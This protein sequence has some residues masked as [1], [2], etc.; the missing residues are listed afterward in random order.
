M[1][2]VMK[3]VSK[4]YV[5]NAK[6]AKKIWPGAVVFDVT[7]GGA[8]EKMDP[9]FPIE[10]VLIPGIKRKKSLSIFGMWE[11]LKIFEKKREIDESYFISEKKLGK[12]RKCKSYGKVI[13]IQVGEN[14][15]GIENAVNDV[16]VKEY[17]KNIKER[18][19]V[20]IDGI[21]KES[22]KRDIVLLDYENERYPISH[23]ELIKRIIES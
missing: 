13:G 2:V 18:F 16:F 3:K 6:A 15:I 23:A 19:G 5:E 20:I 11:G 8:L 22:M 1:V 7:L 9:A 12:S 4:D 10:K 17:E 21:K 14:V